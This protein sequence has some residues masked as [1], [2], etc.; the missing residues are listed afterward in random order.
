MGFVSLVGGI[1]E[2]L[3]DLLGWTKTGSN[4]RDRKAR[5]GTGSREMESGDARSPIEQ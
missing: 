5:R 4:R 3:K 1:K 2:A